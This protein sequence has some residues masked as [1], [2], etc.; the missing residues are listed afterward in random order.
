VVVPLAVVWLGPPLVHAGCGT[1]ELLRTIAPGLAIGTAFVLVYA[2]ALLG[3]ASIR[4]RREIVDLARVSRGPPAE[5]DRM[6]KRIFALW[7]PLFS[8]LD[9]KDFTFHRKK[10][11]EDTTALRRTAVFFQDAETGRDVGLLII[12]IHEHV[13]GGRRYARLT[14]NAGYE[15]AITGKSLGFDVIAYEVCRYRLRHPLTPL[16]MVDVVNSTAAYCAYLK[17]FP[18]LLPRGDRE[19]PASLGPFLSACALAMGA[20][21]VPELHGSAVRTGVVVRQDAPSVRTPSAA[22][23]RAADFYRQATG[24]RA[25]VGLLVSARLGFVEV[26]FASTDVVSRALLLRARGELS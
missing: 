19:P 4:I 18:W 21:R 24:G 15:R 20:E 11:L 10:H 9:G 7:Q 1:P 23:A 6:A 22:R 13:V 17:S 8:H 16:H 26:L 5:V 25:E 2:R 14:L 3:V 12:R